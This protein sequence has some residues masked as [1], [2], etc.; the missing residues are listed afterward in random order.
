MRVSTTLAAVL[1]AV[2]PAALAQLTTIASYSSDANNFV[3][4][5]TVVGTAMPTGAATLVDTTTAGAP[6]S[7]SSRAIGA[8]GA[9]AYGGAMAGVVG[10][11]GAAMA[12]L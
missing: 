12:L 9:D 6:A 10:V 5:Q 3:G 7:T 2:L 8:A 11:V 1:V 4:G